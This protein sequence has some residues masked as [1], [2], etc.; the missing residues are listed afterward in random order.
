MYENHS[1]IKVIKETNQ[2]REIVIG[3]RRM[4]VSKL[5]VDIHVMSADQ[6]LEFEFFIYN[7]NSSFNNLASTLE[8]SKLDE[9]HEAIQFLPYENE[10]QLTFTLVQLNKTIRRKLYEP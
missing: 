4:I 7:L 5:Y 10:N 6:L 9:Q 1:I 3:K 2:C 8:V